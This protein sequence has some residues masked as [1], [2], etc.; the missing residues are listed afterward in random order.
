MIGFFD[1]EKSTVASKTRDF[2]VISNKK[3]NIINISP[4]DPKTFILCKNKKI[5]IS[6]ISIST[7]K[8]RFEQNL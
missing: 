1:L 4:K 6:H 3:N 2:L 7:L 8:K 5:Y